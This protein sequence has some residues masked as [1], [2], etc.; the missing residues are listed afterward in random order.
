M[1]THVHI[2]IQILNLLLGITN[3]TRGPRGIK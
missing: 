3:I 2:N 1:F